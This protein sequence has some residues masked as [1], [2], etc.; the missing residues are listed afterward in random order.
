[1]GAEGTDVSA[2]HSGERRSRRSALPMTLELRSLLVAE[3]ERARIAVEADT[4]AV[5]VWD[6]ADGVMRTLVNIG[7]IA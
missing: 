5:S 2:N 1:M 4:A 7:R 3:A 6:R